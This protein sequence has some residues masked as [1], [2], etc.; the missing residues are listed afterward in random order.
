MRILVVEDERYLRDLIAKRLKGQGYS[1]DECSDGEA[2]LA[3]L[4][5]GSYDCVLL[6]IMLP[7]KDGLTV[8]REMRSGHLSTPVMLLTARDSIEDR[9]SGL[10]A[11]ADDYVVKPF[12]FDELDARVRALLR[13][14]A[15]DKNPVLRMADLELDTVRR[16]VQ[17]A[18]RPIDLT[19]K[20]FS[21][22][23]YFM[24]N[25][26]HVLT[27]EQILNHVWS[28]D[29]EGDSNIV[30]VYIRYL[31]RKMDR[32]FDPPLLHTVRGT[33]YVLKTTP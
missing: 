18:G 27:R 12:S 30:D 8:L 4:D 2:A 9:V 22:L 7:K 6:D 16:T 14:A 23:E 21:L 24:R 13:R 19:T 26:E 28:Y 1:V 11:G 5:E 17:R 33:G 31:R 10:D 25:P 20:E 29:F 3:A 32:G 15:D